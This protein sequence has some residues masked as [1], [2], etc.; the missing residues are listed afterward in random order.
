MNHFLAQEERGR[1]GK[2]KGRRKG[3]RVGGRVRLL[4][5]RKREIRLRTLVVQRAPN[6]CFSK[7]RNKT[8]FSELAL[9]DT[10]EDN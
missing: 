4:K 1:E 5:S 3:E 10:N 9:E 6:G 8:S 7:G 2:K